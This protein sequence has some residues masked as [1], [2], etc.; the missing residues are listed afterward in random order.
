MTIVFNL[1]TGDSVVYRRS[2]LRLLIGDTAEGDGPRPGQANFQ[3]EELDTFLI[4]EDDNLNRTVALIFETLAGEWARLAGSYR[5]GP[6]TEEARQSAAFAD[7]A[8]NLREMYGY[9]IASEAGEGSAILDWSAA[10]DD[11]LGHF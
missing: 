7:R 3:D 5:L 1:T 6:E 8:K 9:A 2:Q 10:Y 11:W 4:L